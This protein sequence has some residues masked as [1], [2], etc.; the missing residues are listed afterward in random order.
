MACVKKRRAKS[1]IADAM[2]NLVSTASDGAKMTW[3]Y[4]VVQR[5]E[6]TCTTYAIHEVF[7][8]NGIPKLVTE[9][10]VAPMGESLEELRRDIEHYMLALDKPILD[11]D[12]DFPE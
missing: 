5:V 1:T 11:Y 4:R 6:Q 8:G 7:Y 12:K 3:N 9:D 10:A 2:G